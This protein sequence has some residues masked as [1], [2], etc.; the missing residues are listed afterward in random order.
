MNYT[1]YR[2]I[3]P[4]R[5]ENK[6]P[7]DSL[8]DDSAFMAQPKLNGSNLT[9]YTDGNKVI[10]MTRHN[11]EMS[12]VLLDRN[13]FK[14]LH[15]GNGWMAINGEYMNKSKNDSNNKLFNHKFV[16][17]DIIVFNGRQTVGMTFKERYDL[18]C[19]LYSSEK[20]DN[21]INK[22]NNWVY[23]VNTFNSNFTNIFKNLITIDMYEGL[24]LKQKNAKLK[25]GIS[26]KNNTNTQLKIRKK[27]KN[28][29]Y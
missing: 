29:N 23:I 5:P 21:Y 9:V 13:I 17:F 7:F 20:C 16:I 1:K 4:P 10:L 18:L 22:I 11:S 25:N 28:Y 3:Y 15:R 6:L 14:T 2:Y 8:S 26:Q 27:T 24:V 12:N 19:E